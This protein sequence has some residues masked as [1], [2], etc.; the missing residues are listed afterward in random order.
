MSDTIRKHIND[1]ICNR[2]YNRQVFIERLG[3]EIAENLLECGLVRTCCN[4]DSFDDKRE[5]CTYNNANIR[6]P[7]KIIATGCEKH[8]DLIPF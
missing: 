2:N 4:C 7:A 3:K 1:A 5:V 6:P 8:N